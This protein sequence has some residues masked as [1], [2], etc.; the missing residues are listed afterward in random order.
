VNLP[1][2]TSKLICAGA[3][4]AASETGPGS[5]SGLYCLNSGKRRDMDTIDLKAC[6]I[7]E[8]LGAA[9]PGAQVEYERGGGMHRFVIVHGTLSYDVGFPE[10]LLEACSA[11]EID[12]AV[13]LF[14][15]RVRAGA[16][17]RRIKIG[18]RSGDRRATA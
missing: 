4:P 3:V 15:E 18:T 5:R 7:L 12:R 2:K 6:L 10:R 13:R 1:R 8:Q 14:V 9:I 11:E 17:P 16:G